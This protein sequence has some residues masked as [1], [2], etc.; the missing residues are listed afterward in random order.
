MKRLLACICLQAGCAA[1]QLAFTPAQE[2]GGTSIAIPLMRDATPAPL[3]MPRA[4]S[5]LVSNGPS[6]TLV[7][8]YNLL[9]L[10]T[11]LSVKGRW[12][13]PSGRVFVLAQIAWKV[14]FSTSE[15]DS[16]TYSDFSSF[17][18]T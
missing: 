5:F 14:P 11:S 10:W 18:Q 12:L 15:D 16:K 17:V 2:I 4:E 3:E 7:D 1:A 8:R 6:R 9:D 13:D